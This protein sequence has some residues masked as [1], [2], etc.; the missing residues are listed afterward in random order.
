MITQSV[1][2]IFTIKVYKK[3]IYTLKWL[4]NFE[5]VK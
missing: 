3:D 4:G 1:N 2:I 5:L